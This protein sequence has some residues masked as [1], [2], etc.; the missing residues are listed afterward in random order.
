MGC[1][2][3]YLFGMTQKGLFTVS[4][5]HPPPQF[6][7]SVKPKSLPSVWRPRSLG[8]EPEACPSLCHPAS[9]TLC[10][11]SYRANSNAGKINQDTNYAAQMCKGYGMINGKRRTCCVISCNLSGCRAQE[12]RGNCALFV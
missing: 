1:S 2:S 4:M 11:P 12:Q 3:T 8:G 6:A 9:P 10:S 5:R 7:L